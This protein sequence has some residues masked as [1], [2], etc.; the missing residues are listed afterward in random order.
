MN[1]PTRIAVEEERREAPKRR[2]EQPGRALP[3]Q[4]L[5]RFARR[6][7]PLGEIERTLTAVL[8]A[9]ASALALPAGTGVEVYVA[10]YWD[11]WALTYLALTWSLIF[12]SSPRQTRQ[13]AR[14][15]RRAKGGW[16]LSM[17]MALFLV[18][19]TGSLLF[20]AIVSQMGLVAAVVLL[21][22]V[23]DGSLAGAP[24]TALNA[25][26]VVAAWAVLNTAYALYYASMYY[27]DEERSGGLE[28]PGDKE[29]RKLDF[30]YFSF[31]IGTSFATSDVKVTSRTSRR[32]VLGHTILSFAYNTVLIAVV[33]NVITDL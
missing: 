29:P 10:V 19:R 3:V 12:R 30:A 24:L 8:T 25:L 11:V 15:Q 17:A 33:I 20:I 5:S 2:T 1:V 7:S 14:V 26:G 13:W 31:T 32:V 4:R 27:K 6:I 28:F 16:L 23:R 21:P 9:A 22:Q 18:G